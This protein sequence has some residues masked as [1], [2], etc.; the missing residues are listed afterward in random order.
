MW[1][2]I[3]TVLC[4]L[5]PYLHRLKQDVVKRVSFLHDFFLLQNQR[6]GNSNSNLSEQ[7]AGIRREIT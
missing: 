3:K 2:L 4:G 5:R 6:P 1:N 7:L